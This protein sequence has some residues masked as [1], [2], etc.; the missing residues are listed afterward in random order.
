MPNKTEET[1]VINAI[2][3]KHQ[4]WFGG[5]GCGWD[6]AWVKTTRPRVFLHQA[7]EDACDRARVGDYVPALFVQ[8]MMEH[9]QQQQQQQLNKINEPTTAK[10]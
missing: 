10:R 3:S 5:C 7:L 4:T 9:Q 8:V 6:D 1:Q 2:V